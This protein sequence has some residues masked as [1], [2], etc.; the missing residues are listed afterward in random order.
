MVEPLVRTVVP[1]PACNV[2]AP[3]SPFREVTTPVA[4]GDKASATA[5]CEACIA[6]GAGESGVRGANSVPA[7]TDTPRKYPLSK[8][9]DAGIGVTDPIMTLN[10]PLTKVMFV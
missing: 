1:D 9:T 8:A 10:M 4:P 2:T 7:S 3:L 5:A 6:Y